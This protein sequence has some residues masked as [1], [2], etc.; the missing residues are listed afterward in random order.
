MTYFKIKDVIT[1]ESLKYYS[2]GEFVNLTRIFK[3]SIDKVYGS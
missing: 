1:V 3:S 2:V